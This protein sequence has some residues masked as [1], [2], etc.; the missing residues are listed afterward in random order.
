MFTQS[1]QKLEEVPSKY[2]TR[3]FVHLLKSGSESSSENCNLRNVLYED[4]G[5]M[6]R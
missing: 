1:N 3:S 5:L 2:F 4:G 6:E